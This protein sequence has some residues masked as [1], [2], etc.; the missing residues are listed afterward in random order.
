MRRLSK[1]K[2]EFKPEAHLQRLKAFRFTLPY[3]RYTPAQFPQ[4]GLLSRVTLYIRFEF[5]QPIFLPAFWGGRVTAARMSVP[6][7]PMHEDDRTE[8]RQ[9]YVRRTGKITTMQTES[10]PKSMQRLA[11]NYLWLCVSTLDRPHNVAS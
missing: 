9:D 11:Y 7:T 3:H 2:I 10:E 5:R 8:S 1:R 6:E 4:L